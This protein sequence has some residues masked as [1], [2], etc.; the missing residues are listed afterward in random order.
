MAECD[1][2]MAERGGF[3]PPIR[4]HVCRISSAVHS[5]TLPPLR[6][7]PRRSGPSCSKVSRRWDDGRPD[8]AA[9]NQPRHWSAPCERAGLLSKP[10]PR[11]QGPRDTIFTAGPHSGRVKSLA[12]LRCDC[13]RR[14]VVFPRAAARWPVALARLT[15][16]LPCQVSK[17]AAHFSRARNILPRP[18]RDDTSVTPREWRATGEPRSA[19]SRQ[20]RVAVPACIANR[21]GSFGQTTPGR[22]AS[23]VSS[24]ASRSHAAA[25]CCR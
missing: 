23:S 16:Q 18:L 11:A 24:A 9:S 5:T 20:L 22:G 12:V 6:P 15:A 17:A 25:S 3:E 13:A 7:L 14:N 4:L 2:R 8:G 10:G 21:S 1:V 19:F